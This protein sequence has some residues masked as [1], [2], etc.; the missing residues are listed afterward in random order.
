[1]RSMGA[2]TLLCT[3]RLGRVLAAMFAAAMLAAVCGQ[4][5]LAAGQGLA[6]AQQSAAS[7][8]QPSSVDHLHGV[9]FSSLTGKPVA[10]V[11]VTSMGTEGLAVMTDYEG[12][13]AFDLRRPVAQSDGVGSAAAATDTTQVMRLNFNLRRPGY[14]TRTLG[15]AVP[16]YTPA[17]PEPDIVLKITPVGVITG[18]V[19]TDSGQMPQFLNVQ[20]R[21][22]QINDGDALYLP[23]GVA[24]PDPQ[25]DFR[26]AE[27]EPG[28]YKLSIAASADGVGHGGRDGTP[29]AVRGVL[30]AYFP[31]ES[32]PD[33][34]E[35]VHVGPGATVL[36]NL[37][38]RSA[39]FYRV[40][41]PVASAGLFTGLNTSLSPDGSGLN[42]RYNRQEQSV[43]GMLAPGTYTVR[44]N[45]STGGMRGGPPGMSGFESSRGER[46]SASV[47]VHVDAGPVRTSAVSLNTGAEIPVIVHRDFTSESSAS[48]SQAP[49]DALNDA[50]HPPVALN[51]VATLNGT[52]ATVNSSEAAADGE[53]RIRG[54]AEGSYRVRANPVGTGYVASLSCGG[55]DLLREPLVVGPGGASGPI[56]VTLRD[57]AASL[58]V[59]LIGDTE[60]SQANARGVA[61][62][63]IPLDTPERQAFNS[64]QM[65]SAASSLPG[66]NAYSLA[67][68][69]GNLPPG[70]YLLLANETARG[71]ASQLE[72]RN[73]KVL[74]AVASQGTTVTLTPNQKA[75]VRVPV[76]PD[77][78]GD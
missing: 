62:V 7:E 20:L 44:M 59:D 25:G 22:K 46:T 54:V 19:S 23:A 12:R 69:F 42:F 16:M 17:D 77:P 55:V 36:A 66:S 38:L 64:V 53:L 9:V 18:R 35:A 27:L 1:M 57:D 58:K 26:F 70:R 56:E 68:N 41:I 61:V 30:A 43:E 4:V 39:T 31:D 75:E 52:S 51:L 21:R 6:P 2:R 24:Q 37:S 10:R 5:A 49:N 47:T 74:D 3:R 50:L 60:E 63:A 14:M 11:L 40:T 48:A 76:L 73:P 33:S 78:E 15:T 32:S 65:F 13:F 72:Y 71:S 45:S 67:S 34:A 8:T 28:D 29:E